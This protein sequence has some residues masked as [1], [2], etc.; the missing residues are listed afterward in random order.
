M[1]L[2]PPYHHIECQLSL[3]TFWRYEQLYYCQE[4]VS[5]VS[6][7]NFDISLSSILHIST[8]DITKLMYLCHETDGRARLCSSVLKIIHALV[9]S[10]GKMRPATS[11]WSFRGLVDNV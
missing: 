7:N 5:S 9:I 10:K 6:E 11:S 1:D 2:Q 3:R 8:S 4:T